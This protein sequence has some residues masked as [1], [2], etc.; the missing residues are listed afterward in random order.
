[1]LRVRDASTLKLKKELTTEAVKKLAIETWESIEGAAE[2]V[3]ASKRL[4][5]QVTKRKKERKR[6]R[7]K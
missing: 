4:A 7:R 3:Q 1:M 6:R 2:H 5:R